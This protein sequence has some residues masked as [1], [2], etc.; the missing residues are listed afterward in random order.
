MPA[1]TTTAE[2]VKGR[3]AALLE[4]AALLVGIGWTQLAIARRRGGRIV[5]PDDPEAICWCASGALSHA[6]RRLQ[7]K[8]RERLLR[9]GVTELDAWNEARR[10]L[11]A[12]I[13]AAD[14]RLLPPAGSTRRLQAPVIPTWN[15]A[16]RQNKENVKQRMN[17]AA[18]RLRCEAVIEATK[19]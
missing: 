4:C 6:R 15:D 11:I 12:E 7:D 5:P 14:D 10:V 8:D 18:Q 3:A 1:P 17:D 9:V 13:E 16:G 19:Q 2:R